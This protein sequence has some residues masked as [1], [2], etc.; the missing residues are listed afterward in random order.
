MSKEQRR[1]DY[2]AKAKD[3]EDQAAKA[4]DEQS[5]EQWRKIAESYRELA[6]H[7]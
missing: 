3:A 4:K 1:A 7:T 2:L 6:R 5:R